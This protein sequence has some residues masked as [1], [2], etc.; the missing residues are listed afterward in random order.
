MKADEIRELSRD[1]ISNGKAKPEPP[2]EKPQR[3]IERI[4]IQ[5]AE[6][7]Y[8]VDCSYKEKPP[9]EDGKGAVCCGYERPTQKVFSS[10]QAVA[11]FVAGILGKPDDDEDSE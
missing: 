1:I 10:G 6:N 7:G 11:D 2:K 4:G 3:D 9:K 5:L 8:I